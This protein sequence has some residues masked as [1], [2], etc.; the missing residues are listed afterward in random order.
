MDFPAPPAP[1]ETVDPA[2]LKERL[3]AN[4]DILVVDTRPQEMYEAWHLTTGAVDSLNIPHTSFYPEIDESVFEKIPADRP[5]VTVCAIGISSEY[6][7]G[8][9]ADRGYSVTHLADGMHGW[10][11]LY[12][13]VEIRRFDGPGDV[14]QYQRPSSGCLGYLIVSDGE[15]CV[16]DP[17]RAFTE[18]Y[19]ED[20]AEQDATLVGAV[21][22]HI[23]ADH[24]SGLRDLVAG[25]TVGYLSQAA[26]DRGVTDA[27]ALTPLADG[28]TIA[29]GE[30]TIEAVSTPGHTTGMTSFL[31][32]S[33]LLLCGDSL[34]LSGVARPDLEA[35]DD[36]APAAART[37]YTSLHDRILEFPD[38]TIIAPGH[39]SPADRAGEDGTYTAPLGDI[40]SD[41]PTFAMDREEFVT[42]VCSD[43]PP[44]PANY[45]TIIAANLG[46]HPVDDEA[47]FELELGPNNCAV[48]T[49]SAG[50]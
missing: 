5:I 32:G 10:A 26:I 31:V 40:A 46:T 24:L 17:L 30:V 39:H 21:D 35:G 38:E 27:E 49:D 20:A 42:H 44:R 13:T 2:T 28:D 12:E 37:L 43:M 19:H 50:D 48:G 18:R 4:E 34:F 45:Q 7:G 41:L 36:G 3:D 14:Y 9:L 22:T 16:I 1:V 47:A 11:R 8:V 15:A 23:H 33:N 6:V 29:V 25:G